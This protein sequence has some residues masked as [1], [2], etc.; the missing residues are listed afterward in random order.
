M[1]IAV[2]KVAQFIDRV[3]AFDGKEGVTD[4]DTGSNAVD[5]GMTDVLT[6]T[7]ED[8]TEEELRAFIAA[9]NQDER[10]TLVALVWLG[11][12]DYDAGEWAEALATARDRSG[13][14]T[15]RYLLGIPNVG[16]LVDEGLAMMTEEEDLPP[17]RDDAQI[18]GAPK[19]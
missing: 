9:L 12:G 13:P 19:D 18:R 1:D 10:A 7:P 16:D 15:W 3:R 11:R 6:D 14:P 2:D 5:D 8:P 4:L 17:A